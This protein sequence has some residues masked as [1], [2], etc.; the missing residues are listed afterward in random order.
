MMASPNSR[1][2]RHDGSN[3]RAF[4]GV[5]SS[6]NLHFRKKD[7]NYKL[8]LQHPSLYGVSVPSIFTDS[9]KIRFDRFPRREIPRRMYLRFHSSIDLFCFA[10][11]LRRGLSSTAVLDPRP[12]K[13]AAVCGALICL[14]VS[15]H[16][17][18]L[19]V[20]WD[21]NSTSE[22]G[23][24]IERS[25]TGTNFTRV[26]S[27]GA[28]VTSYTDGS[29]AAATQ[30]WYRVSAYTLL[31]SSSYSN[32]TSGTTP[33]STAP[34][35][36]SSPP[37]TPTT[38]SA[39]I[40]S[41]TARA[42]SGKSAP[43]P[44]QQT[45]TISGGSKAVLLRGIGPGLSKF[46]SS[47]TLTDPLLYLYNGTSTTLVAKN[48]NWGGSLSLISTFNR[49]GAF[50]LP[51]YSKDAALSLSLAAKS[52]TQTVTGNYSG[53]AQAE[54]Y[55][56]DTAKSPAGRFTK[57]LTRAS[58]GTGSSVLIGGFVVAGD[59]PI[60]LLVRAVGPSLGSGSN[61]LKDPLLTIYKGDTLMGRNDNW[62]GS[63]TLKSAFTQVGASALA[64]TASKDSALL[65]TLSP[66]IYSA[67][68][69]GVASTSGIAQLELYQMP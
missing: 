69:S 45:F 9:E 38:T 39:R 6:I 17:A 44:L 10:S 47:K 52:Y 54:L 29:L 32:V 59:S 5:A 49:V 3:P 40:K 65:I 27:V 26:A 62:G 68:V 51:G 23:F 46:T 53:L 35:E 48:D 37:S 13:I 22:L 64:S 50:A 56:A 60:R 33:A 8:L 55:D 2:A 58:V 36:P 11:R 16:A 66:G 19:T 25:T 41:Y 24:H 1:R 7:A 34:S 67:T 14:A 42:V 20:R 28:N 18:Q 57:L 43:A 63:S 12:R 31:V 61:L 15:S 30:Y 21:D 4:D